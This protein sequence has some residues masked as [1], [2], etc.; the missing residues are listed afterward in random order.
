MFEPSPG[1]L[2]MTLAFAA[3][4]IYEYVTYD[5]TDDETENGGDSVE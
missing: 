5:G 1:A 2:F 4:G 3:V